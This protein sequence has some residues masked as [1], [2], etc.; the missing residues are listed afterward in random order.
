MEIEINVE[1]L[2]YSGPVAVC[3]YQSL[4]GLTTAL[5][6]TRVLI[7]IQYISALVSTHFQ[8][9]CTHDVIVGRWK[10]C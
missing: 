7:Y 4:S 3:R 2:E 9:H 6:S 1:A 10:S 5:V 8:V